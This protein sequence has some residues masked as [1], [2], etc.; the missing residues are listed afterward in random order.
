MAHTALQ[1]DGQISRPYIIAL[2]KEIGERIRFGMDSDRTVAP[3]Y[4]L[5]L[6]TQFQRAEHPVD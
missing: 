1:A 2:S 6:M 5:K 4:L 3:L